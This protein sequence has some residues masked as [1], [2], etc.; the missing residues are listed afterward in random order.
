MA[1]V[2]VLFARF[3]DVS[4]LGASKRLAAWELDRAL[5]SQV[6]ERLAGY[7]CHLPIV[8]CKRRVARGGARVS[9]AWRRNSDL[10]AKCQVH[11]Q[12]QHEHVPT[13]TAHAGK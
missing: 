13:P 6:A 7:P 2:G 10:P 3:L 4:H 1:A 11:K 8:G 5:D 9:Q 12:K